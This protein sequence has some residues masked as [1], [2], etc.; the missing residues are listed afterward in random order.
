[1]YRETA[2][3]RAGECDEESSYARPAAQRH[4]WAHLYRYNR[5]AAFDHVYTVSPTLILNSRY[6]YTRYI[7]GFV[8]DQMGWDLAGL[9]FSS[10]FINQIN[11]IDPAFVR[12]PRID[13]TGYSSLSV[14]SRNWNPVDTHDFGENATKI[15]GAHTM[16]F[17][18]GYRIY[19]RNSTNDGN[20]SGVLTFGTNWT[21]G[22]FD[23][24][25][26]SPMG[27]G[28][29]SLLYGLPTGGSFP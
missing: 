18:A 10:T 25:A 11:G 29:A 20:S 6:S 19:R 28:L 24:S 3:L 14:Q 17:G 22:P 1:M 2:L 12:F 4:C 26:A 5:G 27:Q 23:T 15:A 16:R 7:D 13:I 9:G 21:R 8:P